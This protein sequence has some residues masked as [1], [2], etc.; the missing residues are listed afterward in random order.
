MNSRDAAYDAVAEAEQIR[1]AI[2]ASVAENHTDVVE[3][4]GCK[5]K[6]SRSHSAE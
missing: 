4:R 1:Q 6:R 2:A 3:G 5:V